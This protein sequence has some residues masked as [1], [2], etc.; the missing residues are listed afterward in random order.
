MGFICEE[1]G[2][3]TTTE[4]GMKLHYK[5]AHAGPSMVK[6]PPATIEPKPKQV[7]KKRDILASADAMLK[8]KQQQYAALKKKWPKKATNIGSE[9]KI[10]A[11]KLKKMFPKE[12]TVFVNG[13]LP[14]VPLYPKLESSYAVS[15]KKMKNDWIAVSLIGKK[16]KIA[17]KEGPF[18]KNYRVTIPSLQT[19]WY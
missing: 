18:P 6:T 1:C 9:E 16:T 2:Y 13:R 10:S 11:A 14:A 15:V 17:W 19:K 7:K 3:K 8:E 5:V 12:T 4:G